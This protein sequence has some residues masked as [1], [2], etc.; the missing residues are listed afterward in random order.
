MKKSFLMVGA[1]M[2]AGTFVGAEIAAAAGVEFSGQLRPRYEY[3][4]RDFNDATKADSSINTRIRLNAKANIDDKT[5]AFI[6]L[7]SVGRFGDTAAAATAGAQ[8]NANGGSRNANVANDTLSD[9]GVH[10][11]YFTLKNFYDMPVDVQVGR[12]EVVLDGHRL[13]G[14][15]GWTAGAQSHDAVRLTHTHGDHT[16]AYIYS[17]VQDDGT[18]A[19]NDANDQAAHILWGNFRGIGGGALSLYYVITE[20]SATAVQNDG[21][22]MQTI[23]ARQAGNIAGFDYR[24]EFY[25]QFGD[26]TN[27]GN[28]TLMGGDAERQAYMFGLRVGRDLGPV[29]VT[30]WYDYLSGTDATDVAEDTVASFDTLFDTGHKFYGFMDRFLNIG[31]TSR[32]GATSVQADAVKGLGL[33]DFAIKAAASPMKDLTVNADLHMFWTAE[34]AYATRGTAVAANNGES[35]IGEEL[36]ITVAHQYSSSTRFTLGYS[37]FWAD[38]LG[39]ELLGGGTA[40]NFKDRDEASWAYVMMDVK[41]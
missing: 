31:T 39:G 33:Q 14:N 23:G 26:G 37:H 22:Y 20:G 17:Q 11:A 21:G 32:N 41:F 9:V 6:Q 8:D 16:L 25:Y 40:A 3:Q 15:T 34:D 35:H 10:Q 13:L 19:N 24:G 27:A 38:D 5:S 2:L 4:D 36:D 18:E 7:Q 28:R 1:M 29:K 12:Q 30:L